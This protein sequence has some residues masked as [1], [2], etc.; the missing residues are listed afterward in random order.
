MKNFSGRHQFKFHEKTVKVSL[1][2]S[3]VETYMA[4]IIGTLLWLSAENVTESALSTV[5]NTEHCK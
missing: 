3:C 4:K 1:S 2:V 5:W